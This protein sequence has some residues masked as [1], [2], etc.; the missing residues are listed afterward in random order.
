[1]E[2]R[3]IEEAERSHLGKESRGKIES[4]R[5]FCAGKRFVP[6]HCN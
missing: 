1:V 6:A 5:C 4:R 3:N 2:V